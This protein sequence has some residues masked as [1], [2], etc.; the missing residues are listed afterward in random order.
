VSP[1][2][3]SL[4]VV[5]ELIGLTFNREYGRIRPRQ[6][7]IR[8]SV[9]QYNIVFRVARNSKGHANVY[10]VRARHYGIL[11]VTGQIADPGEGVRALEN[12]YAIAGALG[13]LWL[14]TNGHWRA[15]F[16]R[17]YHYTADM[18]TGELVL[19]WREGQVRGWQPFPYKLTYLSE[20]ED[21]FAVVLPDYYGIRPA[22]RTREPLHSDYLML[23]GTSIGSPVRCMN[24]FGRD[25]RFLR[26][27]LASWIK[28]VRD[29]ISIPVRNLCVTVT[30]TVKKKLGS[31][32]SML[33]ST[34]VDD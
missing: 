22:R 11:V 23:L 5:Q 25:R 7:I 2:T 26:D 14:L 30:K 18:D 6:L 31:N 28:T 21:H 33:A 20:I 1:V 24:G 4:A 34:E 19:T 15:A 27:V 29:N 16:A 17:I 32:K 8:G 13:R 3:W 12:D 10:V 9:S